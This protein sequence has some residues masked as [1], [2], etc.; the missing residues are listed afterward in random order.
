M[1][2]E[3]RDVLEGIDA[4]R[5]IISED[6]LERYTT[7]LLE[8]EHRQHLSRKER[9]L[10][11]L[12]TVLIEAFEEEHYPIA[13]ASPIEVLSEL[14]AANNL[15]QKDVARILDRPESTVSALLSGKRLLTRDHIEKLSKRFAVSP[16][17]FF[18]RLHR[19]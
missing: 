18:E 6:Q 3:K 1:V 2:L 17:V 12:L 9:E 19:A 5:P 7:A 10:A 16:A 15:C 11:G 8:L 13:N 14:M 4:P